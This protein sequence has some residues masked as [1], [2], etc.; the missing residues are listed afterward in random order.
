MKLLA[1]LLGLLPFAALAQTNRLTEPWQTPYTGTNSTGPHVLGHWRFETGAVTNDSS[2]KGRELK[3]VG[4][5]ASERGKFGGALESFPGWPK[6][7]TQHAAIATNHPSL[8]PKGAFTI[9]LWLQGKVELTNRAQVHLLDKKYSSHNDYQLLLAVPDKN[10]ARRL[11]VNLGFGKD[12]EAFQS[13]AAEFA[14]GEWHHVAFS[15]DGAGSVRF[16]RDGSSFGMVTRAGRGAVSPGTN[17]LCL[18]DRL[19]SY[20]GGFPGL[21]DEVRLCTGA[22]DFTPAS[23]AFSAE[24]ITYLRREKSPMV[25]VAVRNLQPTVLSNARIILTGTGSPAR[26]TT[27]PPIQAGAT[28]TLE[29]PFDTSL[30]AD[31]YDLR[32]RLEIPGEPPVVREE[33]LRI[34]LAAR[35]APRMPVM[36]WGISSPQEFMRELPRLKDL[37]FTHC[38]GFGANIASIWKAGQPEVA[39]TPDAV[40]ATKRMLDVALA[41]NLGIAAQLSP[42][43][44]LKNRPELLR[45]DRAGQPYARRDAI[46][47][48]PGLAQFCENVGTSVAR[49]YGNYPAFQAALINTEV[50]DDSQVSF[51]KFDQEAYRAF[52]GRDIPEEVSIKNGVT[53]QSLKGFPADRVIPDDHPVLQFYRWF[54]T[55]GDGWNGLNSAVHRGLKSTGRTDLWTWSDP[56]IR[57]PSIAGSGGTVDVL[58]Q[59]SYTEPGPLRV[60]YFADEVFAMAALA[61]PPQRVMKMTQ[62]I[63]YRSASA[64]IRAATNHVANPFDDHDPDAAYITIAPMH[65]RESFWTMLSR[66]VAGLMYH[67]WASLVPTDGTHAYKHTQPDTQAE[68]RRLHHDVLEP[69]GPALLHVP[70]RRSEVA[71]LD[72]FTAQMFARRGSYGYSHDEA[73][74]T[75]LHAQLQPEVIFEETLIKRGLDGYKVLVLVDCDVLPASVVQRI[76]AFQQRG[77]ILIGDPNLAPA[78]KADIPI[79]RFTRAKQGAADKAALL[80]HAAQLRTALDARYQRPVESSNPEVITRARRAGAADYVF[81]L[82]DRREAGNYVGQHGLVLDVGLPSQAEVTLRRAGGHVYDLLMHR[83]VPTSGSG[84]LRWPVDLGPCEGGLF[85]VTDKAVAKLLVTAPESAKLGSTARCRLVVGDASGAPINAVFP[86]R[87]EIRDPHG[88]TGEFSGH[89]AAVA[90]TLEL[91]LDFATNDAPGTWE[92]R[93]TELASGHQRTHYL[94]VGR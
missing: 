54:W 25:S 6:D 31:D 78:I 79:P 43:Y 45:V 83:A 39:N 74:L 3:L 92:I 30:R 19:G 13:D 50:R 10:G 20:Y 52:S 60:G 37:G 84:Q 82:N 14:P 5:V 90:G 24:R 55:V 34:T 16:F 62:L 21:L 67:G 61:N 72:S 94:R 76:K 71:Y 93:A 17:P 35:P 32:A 53:W 36:M 12:S 57:V 38:L 33:T 58:N 11:I 89:H 41:N 47:T 15:Y 4:A 2:G 68:F 1:L 8:S 51:S 85:L 77:G 26:T 46:A 7:N 70:D 65:L 88:R 28:H 75:L 49:T 69:I 91:S 59:W 44:Q 81:V 86:V 73:Y 87:V 48:M 80:A 63:W 40:A 66:P 9:E 56:T 64:P 23:L 18:G 42:G 29:V 22:L 27:L